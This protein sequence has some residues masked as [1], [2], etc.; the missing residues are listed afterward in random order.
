MLELLEKQESLTT[1]QWKIFVA[2]LFTIMLDFF[3]FGLIGFVL[4]FFVSDWH[5]TYGQSALILFSSGV[6]SV[7]GGI[8][9]GW[10]GDKIGRRKVFMITILTFSL[11]TGV[12]ALTPEGGWLFL[13]V[14]R[15]IV[16]LGVA[17]VAAVDLPL[18]QEF[19][20]ASKRG[21]ISGLSIGLVPGGGLLAASLS[22]FVGPIIGWR[23]LFAVGLLPAL[24]AF[25]IR[26]WVPESPRWLIG[27]GRIEEAR[28]SLAWALQISPEEI[29]LPT[30]LAEPVKAPWLELFKYPRSIAAGCLT[31]LSQTGGVGLSLWSVTLLMLVLKVSP[32]DASFLMIWTTLIGILGRGFGSWLS[33]ALG[34][35]YAGVLSCLLAAVTM[36]LAGYL[37][38]L[39]LGTISVFYLLLLINSFFGNGNYAIVFPYMA[40]LWPAKLRAS[41]FGL[42][43]GASNL[44]KFIGPAGLAVVV[45]ASNYVSPTATLAAIVPA[46]NYFAVWFILAVFAFL[47]IGIETRGR[48]IEELDAALK[49]PIQATAR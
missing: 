1:N 33:D 22:A 37:H 30:S 10:L 13:A 14:M 11:A 18:L 48:T 27:R 16:G 49:R 19:L 26:V 6:A 8:V 39:Y 47:L 34:R 43:Y 41:G 45:G 44:G 7:P 35:R 38:D 5:L 25:V 2:C 15:F 23:G 20:P 24:M 40:E 28:R 12:M 17:G 9:F 42:V 21:W 29:A 46:F 4:A 3:D 31:G 32:A 36:S